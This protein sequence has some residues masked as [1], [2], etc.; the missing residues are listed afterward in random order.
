MSTVDKKGK[1]HPFTSASGG[2]SGDASEATLLEI[3]TNT[4]Y[5]GVDTDAEKDWTET[6]SILARLRSITR[7]LYDIAGSTSDTFTITN[8][9]ISPSISQIMSAVDGLYNKYFPEYAS[10]VDNTTT[11]DTLYIGKAVIGTLVT[12]ANWQVKRVELNGPGIIT[13]WADGNSNFDNQFDA[14]DTLTYS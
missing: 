13:T 9:T 1:F 14:P 5:I 6:G 7:F 11:A 3:K 2:G 8:T 12:D 10:R 4:D